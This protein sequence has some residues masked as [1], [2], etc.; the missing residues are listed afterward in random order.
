MDWV[1]AVGRSGESHRPGGAGVGVGSG[2]GTVDVGAGEGSVTGAPSVLCAASPVGEGFDC[3]IAGVLPQALANRITAAR[4]ICDTRVEGIFRPNSRVQPGF[5][6]SPF[7]NSPR[8]PPTQPIQ[9]KEV[10][11]VGGFLS[12]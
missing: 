11:P 8:V 3:I 5:G 9:P 2:G 4:K 1:K 7:P 10:R 12:C 6:G